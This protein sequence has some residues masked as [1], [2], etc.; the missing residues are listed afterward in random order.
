MSRNEIYQFD[1]TEEKWSSYG[2][3]TLARDWH[4]VDLVSYDEFSKMCQ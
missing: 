1:P 4:A 2:Q 3:M